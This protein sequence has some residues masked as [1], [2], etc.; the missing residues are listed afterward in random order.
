MMARLGQNS[1]SVSSRFKRS[2]RLLN[3][4]SSSIWASTG[5]NALQ[6]GFA[7]LRP[8]KGKP[9]TSDSAAKCR[10]SCARNMFGCEFDT[11]AKTCGVTIGCHLTA[12]KH[13]DDPRKLMWAAMG[14]NVLRKGY[15]C[16][17]PWHGSPW[18]A[19]SPAA[20]FSQCAVK[21]KRAGP[22]TH[23]PS[24]GIYT[25]A[26]TTL[27]P[28]FLPTLQPTRAP[29]NPPSHYPTPVPTDAPSWPY[30]INGVWPKDWEPSSKTVKAYVQAGMVHP[31]K[32]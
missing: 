20:C 16:V 5:G 7:C 1:P 15:S 26:P 10:V 9:W 23:A 8:W 22:S 12:Q 29:T 2:R 31:K 3:E 30:H 13:L 11:Q 25:L 28:T 14:P 6:Y 19:D 21:T 17:A 4:K 27:S 24:K 32:S 18:K